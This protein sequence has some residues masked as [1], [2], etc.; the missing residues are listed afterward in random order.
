[1]ASE[2]FTYEK[3]P[4]GL[5]DLLSVHLPF[6][7]PLLRRL[8]SAKS[9]GSTD[10]SARLLFASS[11]GKPPCDV[12]IV[13]GIH[14]AAAYLDPGAGPETQMWIYSTLE[15]GGLSPEDA[16]TASQQVSHVVNHAR[17]LG[18]EYKGE[19]AFPGGILIGSIHSSVS[20]ALENAGICFEWRSEFGYDKWLFRV[21]DLPPLPSNLPDGMHW[22]TATRDDCL[23]A[24]SRNDLPRQVYDFPLVSLHVPRTDTYGIQGYPQ[25]ASKHDREALR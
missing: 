13:E 1:M 11:A 22:S 23:L 3:I 25:S 19:L 18:K 9:W 14:F 6:S 12:D 17:N 24:I 15:D 16:G 4:S 10:P 5:L 7:L 21:E 8:Q 20:E 2:V